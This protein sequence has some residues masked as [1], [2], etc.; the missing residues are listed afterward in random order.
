MRFSQAIRRCLGSAAM[1]LGCILAAQG[2]VTTEF[3][4]YQVILDRNPFGEVAPLAVTGTT[5][6]LTISET[7]TKDYEMKAIIDDGEKLQVGV[8]NK[9]TNKH[10]YVNVGQ[11]LDGLQ[12]V[13][14]NYEKEEAVM[15]MGA[16][17]AIIKLHPDKNATAALTGGAAPASLSESRRR[18]FTEGA[19]PFGTGAPETT[20]RPFF[21]DLKRRGASPFQRMGTNSPFQAKGLESFFKPGTNTAAPFASP[22]RPQSSP[23]RPVSAAGSGGGQENTAPALPFTPV[24]APDQDAGII[25]TGEDQPATAGGDGQTASPPALPFPIPPAG[26]GADGNEE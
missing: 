17:T 1:G 25:T 18:R 14:V 2:A 19:S 26:D 11:E 20:R 21:T 9:K 23:F 7:F 3:N 22:F 15:K 5:S 6:S 4:R 16:E 12:L 8:L 10:I 13:S 24:K